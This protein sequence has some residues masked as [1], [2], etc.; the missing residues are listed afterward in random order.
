[1]IFGGGEDFIL[2]L[3]KRLDFLFDGANRSSFLYSH[4][5]IPPLTFLIA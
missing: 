1:M 2:L 5:L 4:G 3:F